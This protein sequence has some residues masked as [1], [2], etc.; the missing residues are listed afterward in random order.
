MAYIEIHIPPKITLKVSA[1][2]RGGGRGGGVRGVGGGGEEKGKEEAEKE[3][4]DLINH[5]TD[6]FCL[7]RPPL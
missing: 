3:E 4:G 5:Q 7:I 2:N 1:T 6:Y